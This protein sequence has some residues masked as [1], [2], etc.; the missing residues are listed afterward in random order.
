MGGG[1]KGKHLEMEA[2]RAV[3]EQSAGPVANVVLLV[4]GLQ[5]SK[6]HQPVGTCQKGASLGLMPASEILGVE[7]SRVH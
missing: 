2:R 6:C 4:C 5:T 7:P 1:Q 3:R